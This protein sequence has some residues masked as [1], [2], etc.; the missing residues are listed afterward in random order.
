MIVKLGSLDGLVRLSGLIEIWAHLHAACLSLVWTFV[1]HT[2][3]IF[4]PVLRRV[5]PYGTRSIAFPERSSAPRWRRA[6]Q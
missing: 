2:T 5:P 3:V 1:I 6:C 4:R